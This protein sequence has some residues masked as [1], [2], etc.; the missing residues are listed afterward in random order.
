MRADGARKGCAASLPL[1]VP[2]GR[3]KTAQR[4]SAGED[5]P[6]V[7]SPVRDDRAGDWVRLLSSL[8]GL[9]S[10]PAQPSTEVL[11]YFLPPSGLG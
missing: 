10:Y 6:P 8:P 4:F 2:Q 7:K 9:A 1:T 11:G 5:G 3:P